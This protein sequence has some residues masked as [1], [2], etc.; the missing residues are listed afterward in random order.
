MSN[1]TTSSVGLGVAIT[2]F[3]GFT[4]VLEH[5]GGFAIAAKVYKIA[6]DCL[7]PMAMNETELPKQE[8][9]HAV[10]GI[11]RDPSAAEKKKK[12]KAGCKD[13]A[14]ER[15]WDMASALRTAMLPLHI[16]AVY[17]CRWQFPEVSNRA[18]YWDLHTLVLVASST[19][20]I[21]IISAG[22]RLVDSLP[23]AVS[24]VSAS[25]R[26]YGNAARAASS[27]AREELKR[28]TD[29]TP[30]Q[31][32]RA[33]SDDRAGCVDFGELEELSSLT[34]IMKVL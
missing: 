18:W 23:Q 2:A 16:Y 5:A 6:F 33:A 1:R 19:F 30:I 9:V 31:S 21:I 20:G 28:N 12:K 8:T 26:R 22:A 13:K 25:A 17:W 14:V 15:S 7:L 4:F 32:S 27:A 3:E 34:T 10:V 11:D 24:E 29:A